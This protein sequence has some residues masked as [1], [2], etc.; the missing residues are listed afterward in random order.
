M[1]KL[2]SAVLAAAFAAFL[3]VPSAAQVGPPR[4]PSPSVTAVADATDHGG[5]RWEF[6]TRAAVQLGAC[7]GG[8]AILLAGDASRNDFLLWSVGCAVGGPVGGGAAL[9]LLQQDQGLFPKMLRPG[10]FKCQE[11]DRGRVAGCDWWLDDHKVK[12]KK[13]FRRHRRR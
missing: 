12:P 8:N 13:K 3:T 4:P 6:G 2:L 11:V 5:N 1:N 7:L 9:A 10:G